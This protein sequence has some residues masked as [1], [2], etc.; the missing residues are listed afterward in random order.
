MRAPVDPPVPDEP[1]RPA[2]GCLV[3]VLLGALVWVLVGAGVLLL[4][5]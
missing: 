5:R 4:L 1:M 2:L 3:G